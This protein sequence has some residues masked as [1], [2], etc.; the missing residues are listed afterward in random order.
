MKVSLKEDK[1]TVKDTEFKKEFILDTITK[2]VYDRDIIY[3]QVSP[4]KA[5]KD[6]YLL[7]FQTEK[8]MKKWDRALYMNRKLS[9]CLDRERLFEEEF[10]EVKRETREYRESVI[11]EK[12]EEYEAS[13]D[14]VAV[15][16]ADQVQNQHNYVRI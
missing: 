16:N 10:A 11:S 3:I 6:Y 1:V 13:V 15:D 5:I 14:E 7:K 12:T 4:S 2:V 9:L 8:L